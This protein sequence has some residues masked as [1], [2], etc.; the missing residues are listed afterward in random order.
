MLRSNDV[1]VN[2]ITVDERGAAGNAAAINC[3]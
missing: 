3:G 2:A 1:I